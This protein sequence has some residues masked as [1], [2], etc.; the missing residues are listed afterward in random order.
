[1]AFRIR[2]LSV[3]AYA[4]GF[5]L[6]HYKAAGDGLETVAAPGFFD[7]AAEMLAGGDMMLV[8]AAEGGRVLVVTPKAGRVATAPLA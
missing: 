7:H 1:M 4:Q 8:S 2:D 6:W 5:T 3:L